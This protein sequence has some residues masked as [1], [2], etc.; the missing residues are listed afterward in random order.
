MRITHRMI[1][2]S[3]NINLQRSLNRLE[4]LSNRL[5]SGKVFQRPSQDP[6]GAGRVMSF[7]TAIKRNEQFRLN[8]D[9]SRG[10]LEAGERSLLSALETLQRIREL[11]VYGA[12]EALSD[13]DRQAIAPEVS[14]L[15]RHLLDIANKEMNGL[16]IFGGHQTLQ[17][18][19]TEQNV[20][21][22]EA[23]A[24]SAID[25][26]RL[27]ASGLRNGRYQ[28]NLD[29]ESG[30]AREASLEVTQSYLQGAVGSITGRGVFGAIDDAAS[31][32]VSAS[33]L[34][35]VES[36]NQETGEVLYRYRSHEYSLD[37]V[38]SY[39]E[40]VALLQFGGPDNQPLALGSVN[41]NID[42]LQLAGPAE[43]GLLRAGDRAVI[44]VMASRQDGMTYQSVQ[45]SSRHRSEEADFTLFFNDGILD[46]TGLE[47]QYFALDTFAYSPS[48]GKP[49]DGSVELTFEEFAE[50]APA[51][52]FHYDSEGFPV[53][54]GDQGSRLQEISPHQEVTMNFNGK[55]VFGGEQEVFQAVRS[56]YWALMENDSQSLGGNVLRQLDLSIDRLL[57]RL[58]ETGARLSRVEAMQGILFN[59]NL[60]LV[61]MRS[62]VED[63]DLAKTMTEFAMQENAYKAA[64][65]TA[66]RMLQPT[67][68]DYLR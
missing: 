64:L 26:E 29:L 31:L 35:E 19:F 21:L 53:Y 48:R 14:E 6:T 62:L 47:L 36:V 40:G 41:V 15:Y 42:D 30:L 68:V 50:A 44:N 18:P 51:V 67:L 8:M 52:V 54:R 57:Q 27:T 32:A 5:A 9:Q 46:N 25:G 2:W 38:Y 12:N 39:H 23:G 28:A 11:S 7:T 1:A 3:A 24:G 22:V 63:I 56:A 59:E 49:Y 45:M 43:A 13:S 37:G 17:P 16:Y 10:W 33:I 20:Y 66:A 55:Q 60:Y 58:S 34:L 4:Q 61:E 65:A